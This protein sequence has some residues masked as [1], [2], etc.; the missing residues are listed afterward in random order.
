MVVSSG[1]PSA[2]SKRIWWPKTERVPVPVRSVFADAVVEDV[3]HQVEILAHRVILRGA[4]C[5]SE[6][7][8]EKRLHGPRVVGLF[9][10]LGRSRRPRRR[11]VSMPAASA[12]APDR[13]PR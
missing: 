10:R 8:A 11:S 12:N 5:R 9:R 13:R 6:T 7:A 4:E 2:R 3:A 1:K